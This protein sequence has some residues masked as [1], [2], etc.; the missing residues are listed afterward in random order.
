MNS[1]K[2]SDANIK[3]YFIIAKIFF[4]LTVGSAEGGIFTI[5]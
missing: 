2:L 3:T 1:E 4:V 5:L